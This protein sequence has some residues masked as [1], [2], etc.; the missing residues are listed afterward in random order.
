MQPCD[1]PHRAF[2]TFED[3]DFI[4]GFALLLKLPNFDSPVT[5]AGGEVIAVVVHLRVVDHV[6]VHGV[7]RVSA[8]VAHGNAC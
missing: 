8:A 7:E 5:R 1:L 6:L 3:S 4:R 2:V